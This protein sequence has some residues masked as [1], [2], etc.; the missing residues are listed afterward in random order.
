[1]DIDSSNNMWVECRMDA[2]VEIHPSMKQDTAV[3]GKTVLPEA[4][5]QLISP[6]NFDA[7]AGKYNS[8][9]FSQLRKLRGTP[10]RE[11]AVTRERAASA[12]HKMMLFLP[13]GFSG[14]WR[15]LFVLK[16]FL[17]DHCSRRI[18][19]ARKTVQASNLWFKLDL[20]FRIDSQNKWLR[21]LFKLLY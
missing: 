1:M 20:C 5:S 9:I 16:S 14:R 2:S 13:N 17:I 6:V 18:F 7:F 11:P 12:A 19:M 21:C 8:I 15:D 4:A 3:M 10:G